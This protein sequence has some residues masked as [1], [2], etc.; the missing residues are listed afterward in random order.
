[1]NSPA[2]D[3]RDGLVGLPTRIWIIG[4][5]ALHLKACSWAAIGEGNHR[6]TAKR[7]TLGCTVNNDAH[8]KARI[9]FGQGAPGKCKRKG[10]PVRLGGL[11]EVRRSP[12]PCTKTSRALVGGRQIVYSAARAGSQVGNNVTICEIR[13]YEP[14][15]LDCL[16]CGRTEI[17]SPLSDRASEVLCGPPSVG[18]TAQRV[19]GHVGDE[20]KAVGFS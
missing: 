16:K 17:C 2:S 5:P 19:G 13:V 20:G 3:A 18:L 6:L 11:G 8:K 4:R 12:L 7:A 15:R 1:M 10:S 9:D 14:S